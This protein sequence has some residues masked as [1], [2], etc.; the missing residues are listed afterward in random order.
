LTGLFGRLDPEQF[1]SSLLSI[2]YTQHGGSG[3]NISLSDL[4][5]MPLGMIDFIGEWLEE[6]R[7]EEA[8]RIKAANR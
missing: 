1:W 3:L 6:T 5:D 8:K 2:C 7:S 4:D